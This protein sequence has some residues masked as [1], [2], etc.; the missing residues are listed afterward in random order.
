MR[1]SAAGT[2][3]DQQQAGRGRG[4]RDVDLQPVRVERRHQRSGLRVEHQAGE[5]EDQHQGQGDEEPERPQRGPGQH[6]HE[7]GD[8]AD[9]RAA[10]ARTRTCCPTGTRPAARPRVTST[11]PWAS[12]GERG[13][14]DRH[15]AEHARPGRGVRAGAGPAGATGE[16][17][18]GRRPGR[19]GRTSLPATAAPTRSRAGPAR[20]PGDRAAGRRT[21]TRRGSRPS[22][23]GRPARPPAAAGWTSSRH[24]GPFSVAVASGRSTPADGRVAATTR[25][26]S[27]AKPGHSLRAR[28]PSEIRL[29][30]SP[31]GRDADPDPPAVPG[32]RHHQ[33]GQQRAR[34]EQDDRAARVVAHG[35]GG[36]LAGADEVHSGPVGQRPRLDPAAAS[37]GRPP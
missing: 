5:A 26:N 6:Q 27:S 20:G 25:S 37:A 9:E 3:P 17:R 2:K 33:A 28:P 14:P 29:R 8:R 36:P 16:H 4:R 23:P 10:P 13:E 15:D 30:P 11:A 22:R 19:A 31:A 12:D 18:G 32:Q 34:A 21:R 24:H 35:Q 7:P 1:N